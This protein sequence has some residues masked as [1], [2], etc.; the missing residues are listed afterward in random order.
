MGSGVGNAMGDAGLSKIPFL[1]AFAN[2]PADRNKVQQMNRAAEAY[3]AY[4]TESA[5]AR[6]NALMNELG[7]LQ[8]GNDALSKMYGSRMA[9]GASPGNPMS[10][11]MMQTGQP[12]PSMRSAN[13]VRGNPSYVPNGD[14]NTVLN[15][16]RR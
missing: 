8:G 14:L 15:P 6:Q 10:P 16:Q 13:E 11:S 9:P 1:G 3:G 12:F 4:R 5:Q 2:D 7:A